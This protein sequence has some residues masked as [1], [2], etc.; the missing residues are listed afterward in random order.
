[1]AIKKKPFYYDNQLKRL[2]VQIQSA[3]SGYQVMSGTQRDGTTDFRTV[4]IIFGDTST[5]ASFIYSGGTTNSM[6]SLPVMSFYMTSFEQYADWRQAPQHVEKYNFIERARDPDGNLIANDPGKKKTIERYMP[7]PTQIGFEV[8]IWS[9]NN[10]QGY[11]LIEQ[12]CSQYNPEQDIQLSNSP[13]DWTFLT[14]LVFGGSVNFGKAIVDPGGGTNSDPIYTFT[15]PFTTIVWLSLPAKVYD[16]TYIY[17]IHV[18]IKEIEDEVDFDSY[19]TLDGLVIRADD[20][21]IIRFDSFN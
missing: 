6:Q 8:S 3:F 16:T 20:Q 7:V 14:T 18:P 13:A 10:D 1:M 11:Q 15:L 19:T 9:S 21:D 5:T 2:L 4:P 12:I 17:E